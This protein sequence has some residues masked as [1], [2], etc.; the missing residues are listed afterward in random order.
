VLT[1]NN[2]TSQITE[3]ADQAAAAAGVP[4]Q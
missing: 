1:Q 3:P 2:I 4:A